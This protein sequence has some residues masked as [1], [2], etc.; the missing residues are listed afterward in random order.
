MTEASDIRPDPVIQNIQ[1]TD[2]VSK[3]K[4]GE[5]EG[6]AYPPDDAGLRRMVRYLM[7]TKALPA[8]LP[9]HLVTG[10]KSLQDLPRQLIPKETSC[11]ECAGQLTEPLLITAAAKLVTYTG[12]VD[13][14]STYCKAC[15]DCGLMYRYQE[16]TDGIHNFNDHI[17]ITL[18]LCIVLRAS[19][20]T[21]HSVSRAIEVLEQTENKTFPKKATILHA[22]MHFEA[23]TSHDYLYSCYKCG[24]HPPVVV[25]DLHRKG[26]FNMP[27]SEMEAPPADFDGT[28]DMKQFWDSVNSEIICSGLLTC[29]RKNPFVVVPSYNNWA[30]WI[31]PKTRRD[32]TVF[33]TEHEKFHAPRQATEMADL[34]MTE[35]RLQD[36][37]INLKVDMVRKLC[38]QCGL[39]SKGSKMDLILRL[40]DEMKN[41]SSYDKIFEKV[42]GASGGWAV[43]MCPCA[44]VYSIKFNLRAESPRDYA[45]ILLSWKHFP[46]IAIYDFARGLATHTNLREPEKLP[47]SPHEGRLAEATT[48]NLQLAGEGKLKVNLPWLKTKKTD[49]DANCHPITGSSD[50]Y[51]LYDIFHERNTKDARDALRRIGLVPELAGWVNSQC[52]EQLFSDMRKNNYF[53]NTLTPSQ[54]IFMMRNILHHYN[55]KCSSKTK[56][57][58]QKVVGKDVQLQLDHNG[59]IVMGTAAPI[60]TDGEETIQSIQSAKTIQTDEQTDRRIWDVDYLPAEQNLLAYVLDRAKDPSEDLLQLSP[61]QSLKRSDFWSLAFD[62]LEA[63]IANQCFQLITAFAASQG[64]DVFAVNSYVVVTWLPPYNNDPRPAL[65]DDAATKDFI[66][67]PS[68]ESGHWIICILKPKS[69]EILFFDSMN[70]GAFG[71]GS[72]IQIFRKL[73][74]HISPGHW[75]MSVLTDFEGAPLQL[76]GI[77]CG[78]FMLMPFDFAASDMPTIR[79]WWCYQLFQAFPLTSQAQQL[80]AQEQ[81]LLIPEDMEVTVAESD[82]MEITPT[83][84]I[85][86][87]A[88]MKNIQQACKWVQE[89]QHHFAGKIELPKVLRMKEE[90]A[91]L[92]ITMRDLFINTMFYDGERNEEQIRAPFLFTFQRVED[93]ELFSQEIRDKRD[94]RVSCVHN[95]YL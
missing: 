54:H 11:V 95:P 12:V 72:Y 53:L 65:P 42:W 16:W 29:G 34:Q 52:A 77:D 84:G 35:K 15:P 41:R 88:V 9:Q 85:S 55:T 59:Q 82:M 75:N 91:L 33:N 76:G 8:Q 68:L 51:T 19:L 6:Q 69:K 28:V 47:F 63:M 26:V 24:Y 39:D 21:H 90:D 78:V 10:S 62:E 20:Q 86:D 48:D 25:M 23:M 56:V 67:L 32:D 80:L 40:R 64:K 22:Y 49:T 71:H 44:V 5:D 61:A 2:S 18:H 70:P 7:E 93:M 92:A 17:L 30:S 3:E 13:G 14:F 4:P 74:N 27:V 81:D 89:N 43:V 36:A 58:I 94:I 60:P 46:N 79:K 31:G 45:D 38:K 1:E 57:S 87:S 66:L 50:H 37:L 83:P 73:A